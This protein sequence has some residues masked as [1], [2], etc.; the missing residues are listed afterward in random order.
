MTVVL[1][2]L[3]CPSL[4]VVRGIATRI[5][6]CDSVSK[7]DLI[8]VIPSALTIITLLPQ[9]LTLFDVSLHC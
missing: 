5:L 9:H 4:N 7:F 2:T 6:A 8:L 1:P 3:T